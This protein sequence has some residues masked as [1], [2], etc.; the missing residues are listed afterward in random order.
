LLNRFKAIQINYDRY[1]KKYKLEDINAKVEELENNIDEV[2]TK[3]ENDD[4]S[5]L[6]TGKVFI[7]FNKQR[8]V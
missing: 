4:Q 5:K 6:Y 8:H 2:K 7:T 1:K 3:I